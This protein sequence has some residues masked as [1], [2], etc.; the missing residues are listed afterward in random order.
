LLTVKSTVFMNTTGP[1]SLFMHYTF[2]P[3]IITIEIVVN[4]DMY[5]ERANMYSRGI[6]CATSFDMGL[7]S[8]EG[9]KLECF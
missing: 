9:Q 3:G 8:A 6:A 5:R 1:K 2:Y 4:R 7:T